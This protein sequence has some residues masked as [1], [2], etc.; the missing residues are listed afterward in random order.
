M[1]PRRFV[2]RGHLMSRSQSFL[3]ATACVVECRIRI[4]CQ[5]ASHQTGTGTGSN[6]ATPEPPVLTTKQTW[7]SPVRT[8][9][10]HG[11]NHMLWNLMFHARK[12]SRGLIAGLVAFRVASQKHV[13]TELSRMVLVEFRPTS[14]NQFHMPKTT[15]TK[16]PMLRFW[17]LRISSR[18]G[19]SCCL[20]FC[21][22]RRKSV[23][24]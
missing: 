20:S 19:Q 15:Q 6:F 4:G 10:F 23:F 1:D 16:V 8:G 3:F 17:L 9:F 13:S 21:P 2:E 5:L 24:N 12:L 7:T 18:K 22:W 14:P 11:K